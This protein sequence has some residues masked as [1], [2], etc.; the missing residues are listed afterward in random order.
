VAPVSGDPGD[1]PRDE[2]ILVETLSDREL[3]VLRLVADGSR[4]HEI[5]RNLYITVK[6]VEFHV[7]NILGKLGARSRTEAAVRASRMGLLEVESVAI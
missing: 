7:S 4:N 5:A 6:T 3:E 2:R 1:V